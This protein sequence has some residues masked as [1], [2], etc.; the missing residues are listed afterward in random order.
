MFTVCGR[1]SVPLRVTEY[2]IFP[3][4]LVACHICVLIVQR[5]LSADVLDVAYRMRVCGPPQSHLLV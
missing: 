1:V 3:Y 2:C 5:G 4:N